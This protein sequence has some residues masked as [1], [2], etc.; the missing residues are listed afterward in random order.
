MMGPAALR[1]LCLCRLA[2]RL[3]AVLCFLLLAPSCLI[4]L[5]STELRGWER[6][7]F[8]G[9][10]TKI[11]HTR[12]TVIR[13]NGPGGR[14]HRHRHGPDMD[15]ERRQQHQHQHQQHQHH[16]QQTP[17]GGR[18]S[19]AA[20][21]T[22]AA[23]RV[24]HL[25]LLVPVLVFL[26]LATPVGSACAN[27]CSGHGTCGVG[28][29]CTCFTGWRGGAP[30]CSMRTSRPAVARFLVPPS[31]PLNLFVGLFSAF[32]RV[33]Q[34]SSVGR[35]GVRNGLG[36][37]ICRMLQRGP[38]RSHGGH[39][40]VLRGFHRQRMPTKCVTRGVP[41]LLIPCLCVCVCSLMF[42]LPPPP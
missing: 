4:P 9:D 22:A 11:H 20:A 18:A 16:Q 29:V 3:A 30:D 12:Q 8:K 31:P 6:S 2:C 13:Q 1:R 35:Q 28:N 37:P 10:P 17:V 19:S 41:L 32:R 24:P 21:A 36:A 40:H 27:S 15:M 7:F 39:V 33:S 25:A 5:E 14:R 34:G 23:R 42:T 26:L 38:V